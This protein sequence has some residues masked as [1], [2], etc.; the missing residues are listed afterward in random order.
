MM[1]VGKYPFAD[2]GGQWGGE[3]RVRGKGGECHAL[4]GRKGEGG[5]ERRLEKVGA[6]KVKEGDTGSPHT[7]VA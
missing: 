3:G 2:N 4:G 5:T 7:L 6:R 1:L